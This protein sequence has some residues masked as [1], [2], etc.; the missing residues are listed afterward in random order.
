M[1]VRLV[2]GLRDDVEVEGTETGQTRLRRGPGV[3]A[4]STRNPVV[5]AVLGMLAER[6]RTE[7][8]IASLADRTGPEATASIHYV[9]HL[10]DTRGHLAR[11][12]EVDDVPIAT[13]VSTSPHFRYAAPQV[14]S[15]ESYMMSRFAYVRTDSGRTLL[16]SPRA[17][18]R[19]VLHDAR[20]L[21]VVHQLATPSSLAGLADRVGDLPPDALIVLLAMLLGCDMVSPLGA[22]GVSLEETVESLRTWEFH[23]LLFHTRSRKGR[24]DQPAG[25]TWR[26]ADAADPPPGLV[27]LPSA[28]TTP[29]PRPDLAVRRPG[30]APFSRVQDSRRSVRAYGDVPLR[31]E[32]LGEFLFRVGRLTGCERGM[33]DTG[34]RV[35]EM[36]ELK[37]PYPGGGAIYELELYPVIK[38]CT[39]VE[40]GLY[41]YDGAGHSLGRLAAQSPA[42]NELVGDAADAAGMTHEHA[43]VLIVISARFSRMAWK[44]ASI[45]YASTLK[46]VGILYQTMYLVATAMGLGPCAVGYGDSELFA[47]AIASDYYAEASVGE[48]LLGG[49]PAAGGELPAEHL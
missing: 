25:A 16:E 33:V 27:P 13:L 6:H 49:A 40:P 46:H 26:F 21:C 43:Q 22:D 29:L 18:A 7:T 31:I 14:S 4:V 44:Y 8:D 37:R 20:A 47:R 41:R 3:T 1:S 15:C 45:S 23:D 24:H 5:E 32:Q 42:V 19:L 12:V 34:R 36:E 9:L 11:S 28:E 35:I 2:L 38:Q 17:Y 30:E 10:L 39:G 48:F